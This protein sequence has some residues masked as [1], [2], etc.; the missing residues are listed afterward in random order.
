MGAGE[1]ADDWQL[2]ELRLKIGYTTQNSLNYHH[3]QQQN[4]E[5]AG[6]LHFHTLLPQD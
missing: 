1:D 6:L 2:K 3:V 5:F 4:C